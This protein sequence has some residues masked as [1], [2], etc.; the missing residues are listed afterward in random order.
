MLGHCLGAGSSPDISWHWYEDG[1][2]VKGAT[3]EHCQST[4]ILTA[5]PLKGDLSG[6]PTSYMDFFCTGAPRV[7]HGDDLFPRIFT[8]GLW[9]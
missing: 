6:T 4:T 2:R 9:M 5:G 7:M 1:S 3:A 8:V